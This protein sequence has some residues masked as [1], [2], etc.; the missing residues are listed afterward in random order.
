MI[1]VLH[2]A[3]LHLGD[4]NG[5]VKDGRNARREDTLRC[6]REIAKSAEIEQPNVTI[7]A[8]D[9]FNRSRVWADTALDDIDAAIADFIRPLCRASEKVVLL[10]GT[11]N[12]DNPKAFNTLRHLTEGLHNLT[13]YTTPEVDTLTTSAGPV[14]ILAMP[15]FDKDRLRAFI[16]DADAETENQNATTLVN[17]IIM[18]LSAEAYKTKP[19]AR[20]LVAHYTNPK[21][22][23][24][25]SQGRTW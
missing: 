4:L 21:A 2:C 20:I 23:R 6:M 12:H 8:G 1:K 10:F 16:P 18:G 14:Q 11:Q 9:L 5:P 15:G 22:V 17:E 24:L 19:A 7:I 3:D 13:I 25:S